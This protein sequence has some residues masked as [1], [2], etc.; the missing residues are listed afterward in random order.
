MTPEERAREEAKFAEKV[1][2]ALYILALFV[3]VVAVTI[4]AT[5]FTFMDSLPS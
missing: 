1:N 4:C 5:G 2:I 3:M